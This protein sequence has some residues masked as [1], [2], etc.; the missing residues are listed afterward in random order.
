[1]LFVHEQPKPISMWMKNT[2]IPLDMVFIDEHGRIQQIVEQTTPHS[3]DLIRSENPALAVLEIAGGEAQR[4]GIHPGQHVSHPAL[5]A[6]TIP[7]PAASAM[8][9]ALAREKSPMKRIGTLVLGCVHCGIRDQRHRVGGRRRRQLVRRTPGQRA[10]ARRCA[11]ADDDAGAT[12]AFGRMLNPEL[13]RRA[14][15]FRFRAR[16]RR[17]TTARAAGFSLSRESRVLSRRPRE[18]VPE[19]RP[20]AGQDHPQARRVDDHDPAALYGVGLLIHARRPARRRQR[21]CSC[22]PTSA[23][24]A[25]SS[26]D[27]RRTRPVDYVGRPRHPV[28]LGRHAAAQRRRYRRRRRHATTSTS[29]PARRPAPPVDTNGCPLPQDDDGDGVTNDIDKCPGT[30]AGAKVDATGCELDSDGDGVG[31]SR[32]QCPNTPAGRQGRREGLRARQRRRR[33]RRQPGQVPRHAEGRSRGRHRAA[34]SRRRSNY[35]AW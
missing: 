23:R 10:V 33:R 17:P 35:P 16:S 28:L 15:L 27:D 26:G 12:L 8:I 31:D 34:R 30:P 25:F 19:P 7:R 3:L 2:Y 4:L 1:M 13:G 29:A 6:M 32:D 22:A 18:S 24:G 21:S 14:R 11:A 5:R 20:R 9:P